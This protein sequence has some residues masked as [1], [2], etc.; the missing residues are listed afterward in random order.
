MFDMGEQSAEENGYQIRRGGLVVNL[1]SAVLIGMVL[2]GSRMAWAQGPLT[3]PGAPAPTMKTLDEIHSAVGQVEA[4]I[5]LADVAG[6]ASYHHVIDAPGS[7]YLSTNLTVSLS[8][9]III[10]A[11]GVTIDL[12]GYQISR[13]SGSGG[14]GI[15][16]A[17]DMDDLTVYNGSIKGFSYGVRTATVADTV[18]CRFEKVNFSACSSYGLR[19]GSSS[20]VIDCNAHDNTGSGIYAY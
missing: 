12:N 6:N 16:I 20:R 11:S 2:L 19:A 10:N 4:R 5:D 18:G 3:P 8:G 14:Y 17:S 15:Y 13:L 9:G 7:Y 1:K